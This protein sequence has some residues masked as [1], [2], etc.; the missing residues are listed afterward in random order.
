MPNTT[1]LAHQWENDILL[2]VTEYASFILL[3]D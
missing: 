2:P 3:L 1:W